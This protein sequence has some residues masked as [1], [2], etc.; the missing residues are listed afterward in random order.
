MTSWGVS[1]PE[2]KKVVMIIFAFYSWLPF[3][4]FYVLQ[5]SLRVQGPAYSIFLDYLP[6]SFWLVSTNGKY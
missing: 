1:Y 2:K 4:P 6:T 3:L 5:G